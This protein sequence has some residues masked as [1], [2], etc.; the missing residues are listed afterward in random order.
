[1]LVDYKKNVIVKCVLY[2][3]VMV[4]IQMQCKKYYYIESV[5]YISV[6]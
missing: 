6:L 3:N 4:S 5:N 1:M 2:K